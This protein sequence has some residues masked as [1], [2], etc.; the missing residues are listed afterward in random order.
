[1]I[2]H[3]YCRFIG[4]NE[5]YIAKVED[6]KRF[7]P[8][9]ANDFKKHKLYKIKW[10]DEVHYKA[11][12]CLLGGKRLIFYFRDRLKLKNQVP[13]GTWTRYELEFIMKTGTYLK[14]V[15]VTLCTISF[16]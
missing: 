7:K 11:H 3:A 1:M 16:T 2:T 4:D 8:K 14:I 15:D 6:V 5:F 9:N 12:I 13:R 10:T